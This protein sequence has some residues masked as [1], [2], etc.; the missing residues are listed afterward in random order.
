[1]EISRSTTI[2]CSRDRLFQY[3]REPNNDPDWCPTVRS[4]EL[5]EGEAGEVGAVYR[6]MHKPGPFPPSALEVRLLEIGGPEHIKLQ[7][8]DEI[9]TFI[10]TY[11]LE[12]LGDG[13]TRVIQHDD[14]RF[15]GFGR[16]LAPFISI[17]VKSGIKRQ[18]ESLG[19][20]ARQGEI[21]LTA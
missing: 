2:E 8:I 3:L 15:R 1:M 6:Q 20:M 10:V 21:S 14:I 11:T 17:A 16:L 12:D 13:M 7:S 5:A 19:D 9:A 18:F 4:S